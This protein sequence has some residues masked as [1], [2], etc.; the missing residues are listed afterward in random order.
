MEFIN[1]CNETAWSLAIAHQAAHDAWRSEGWYIIR[2]AETV[3]MCWSGFEHPWVYLH[4]ILENP[5]ETTCNM[6]Q[7]EVRPRHFLRSGSFCINSVNRFNIKGETS[8]QNRK[9]VWTNFT[10]EIGEENA[11][12]TCHQLGSI[13]Y[14]MADFYEIAKQ[15]QFTLST[16]GEGN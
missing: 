15:K 2:P 6:G 16:C 9:Q 14:F 13:C 3:T 4:R 11:A 10:E 8:D 12:G 1:S 7:A 5:D